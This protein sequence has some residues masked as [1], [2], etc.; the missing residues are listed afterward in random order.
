M[1]QRNLCKQ[2]NSNYFIMTKSQILSGATVTRTIIVV[3][4]LTESGSMY[5]EISDYNMFHLTSLSL[6]LVTLTFF[7]SGWKNMHTR[8]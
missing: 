8:R 6:K 2:T 5:L 7:Q 3:I 4:T 1:I